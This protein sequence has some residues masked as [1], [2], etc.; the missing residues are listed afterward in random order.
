MSRSFPA[1][2]RHNPG[3]SHRLSGHDGAQPH[4]RL[5]RRSSP[6]SNPDHAST[7]GRRKAR[8]CPLGA[9]T[10][11][12]AAVPILPRHMIESMLLGRV[13][14]SA[15]QLPGTVRKT[16]QSERAVQWTMP[17]RASFRY[18]GGCDDS[19]SG[20][21]GQPNRRPSQ[22]RACLSNL[23]NARGQNHSRH[24]LRKPLALPGD[25]GFASR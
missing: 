24:D 6:T 21:S 22:K 25:D 1:W 12:F 10:P 18:T 4:P 20:F 5:R 8:E 17:M 19:S 23:P 15:E 9:C 13:V 7:P 11:N 14:V 3:A 2:S 16:G